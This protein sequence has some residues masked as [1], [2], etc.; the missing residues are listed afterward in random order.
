LLDHLHDR[1]DLLC[2]R[3]EAMRSRIDSQQMHVDAR[4][5]MLEAE[6]R[7]LPEII[8]RSMRAALD[9]EAKGI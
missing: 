9:D 7:A 6:L 3:L 2:M 8:E 1:V 5:I 4:I